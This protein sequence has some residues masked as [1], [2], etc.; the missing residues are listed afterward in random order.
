MAILAVLF[1]LQRGTKSLHKGKIFSYLCFELRNGETA[2]HM[3]LQKFVVALFEF[4]AFYL[5][6]LLSLSSLSLHLPFGFI[7]FSASLVQKFDQARAF[8]VEQ[9]I[10]W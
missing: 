4:S 6:T 5:R 10:A 7:P 8:V 3:L 9:G 1:S 2:V